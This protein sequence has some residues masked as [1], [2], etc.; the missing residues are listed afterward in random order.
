MV[1]AAM[2]DADCHD[3]ATGIPERFGQ[4]RFK[5]RLLFA[6]ALLLGILA[7]QLFSKTARPPYVSRDATG[8][9]ELVLGQLTLLPCEIGN[10]SQATL[11]AY[12][13][14]FS[15]PEN[16]A[17]VSGRRIQLKVAVVR[18]DS[19]KPVTELVTFLDGGPGGAATEDF[20]A[21]APA[22][23]PLLKDHHV[24]LVDQ[25]GTGSSNALAC[26]VL[27]EREKHNS[28]A[29]LELLGEA[30]E[31][32]QKLLRECL[33]EI[34]GKADPQFYT[35]TD[36]TQDLETLRQ[37][38][39][40]PKLNLVGISY[41]TRVAQQY[42]TRFPDS[43]RSI[44]LD[45]AVPNTLALGQ[46]HARNLEQALKAQLALCVAQ[47]E[48]QQRFGDPY[49]QLQ[50]LRARLQARPVTAQTPDPNTYQRSERTL[51]HARLAG[52][53]RLYAYNGITSA[54]LPLM[55]DEALQ[56]N[57][58]PL[59][60]QEKLVTAD[61]NSRMTGA[62]GLSV[63]CSEDADLLTLNDADRDTLMGNTMIE[64]F[65]SVC[66]FWPH[67]PRPADFHQ[68]F[69]SNLPVLILA[70]ELDPVTPPRYGAEILKTLP[71]ARLLT[72]PGQGH[73][74]IGVRCVPE[75][76]SEF[77]A[78]LNVNSLDAKCLETLKAPPAFLN[79]NGAAP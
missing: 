3:L 41:G 74:I 30:P 45:S 10:A 40:S 13:T 64:F 1:A 36:A 24:L 21:I 14:R 79:Y 69:R 17:E 20:L 5:P 37:A 29:E 33:N 61:V 65:Q 70:G 66:G 26:P 2:I 44:V 58:A 23:A 22:F 9:D 38:L 73:G 15:V 11:Q 8:V 72:A 32:V 28:N 47:A 63:G 43:V 75:L 67:R 76:V 48:C 71:N 53:V 62:M 78:S 16:H 52:L 18:S 34:T 7:L 42:A 27:T 49:A 4:M 19:A 56:G 57:Y 50:I 60:G 25:R 35:T 39:G 68:P 54:L 31:Q 12:C 59:L 6:L 77:V 46:E 55:I 51:T